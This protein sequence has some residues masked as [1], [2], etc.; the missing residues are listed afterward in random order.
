MKSSSRKGHHEKCK[1]K[2][3]K[4]EGPHFKKVQH[5]KSAQK[6]QHENIVTR[7][8]VQGEKRAPQKI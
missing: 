8:M 4:S 3:V 5:E 2:Q 6:V 1:T 7:K